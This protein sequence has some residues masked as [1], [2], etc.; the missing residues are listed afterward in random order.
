MSTERIQRPPKILPQRR[1]FYFRALGSGVL[2]P[3]LECGHIVEPGIWADRIDRLRS[4]P[5]C[6]KEGK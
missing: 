4:C 2:K 1:I 3:V 6:G 5:E